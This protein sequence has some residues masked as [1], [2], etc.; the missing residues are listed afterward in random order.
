ML[1]R[2]KV[3][4]T[5]GRTVQAQQ[6]QPCYVSVTEEADLPPGMDCEEAK[7]ELYKSATKSVV[8]MMS[9]ELKK[10]SEEE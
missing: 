10:W 1:K 2:T 4:V 3:S 9:A 5:V 8:R 6:Y 7:L